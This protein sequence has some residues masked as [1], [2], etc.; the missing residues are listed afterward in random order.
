MDRWFESPDYGQAHVPHLE[1][2]CLLGCQSLTEPCR[3]GL[4]LR[5]G[6][7]QRPFPTPWRQ[8]LWA[9]RPGDFLEEV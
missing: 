7:T 3:A 1:L 4:P 6:S 8:I 5:T 9:G 2:I